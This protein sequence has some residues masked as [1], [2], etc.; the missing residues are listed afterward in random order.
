MFNPKPEI[1]QKLSELDYS[2]AQSSQNIFEEVPAITY[3]I[4]NDGANYCLGK[5]L[6]HQDIEVI[7]DIWTDDSATGSKI[8]GE[9]ETKM[10][11]IDYRLK[12]SC[13]APAPKGTLCHINTR[14]VAI[15]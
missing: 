2:V 8:L 5:E 4:S 3:S 10:R 12:T 9:V 14:F 11:E 15:K 7:I 6:S 13:D 1:Y